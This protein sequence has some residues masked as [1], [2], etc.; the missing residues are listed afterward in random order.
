MDEEKETPQNDG[1]PIPES[2]EAHEA[3]E[4]TA[5]EEKAMAGGWRPEHEWEGDPEDWVSAREFNFRG[6]LMS[7]ITSQGRQIGALE[8]KLGEAQKLI[9]AS[10]RVT[11]RLIKDAVDKTK[12]D[13]KAARRAA[14]EEGD[15]AKVDDID[16]EL[17]TLKETE[18]ELKKGDGGT[19]TQASADQQ[20]PPTPV[21]AAWFTY[22]QGAQ[23][24]Q[25]PAKGQP[26]LKFAQDLVNSDPYITVDDFMEQVVDKS[27]EL[28]GTAKPRRNTPPSGP[29]DTKGGSRPRKQRGSNERTAADL[30]EQQ[31]EIGKGYVAE[32]LYK[33]LDEYAKARFAID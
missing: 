16:E 5:A 26:M 19:Q 14:V 2:Q 1:T 10:D 21:E 8:G 22:V 28:R 17:D 13:L 20:R 4:P 33:N 29:D 25:D 9:A 23:W 11:Q 6:E 27:K 12:R 32:G 18:A 31:R 24:M 7:R 15:A 3:W 30:N